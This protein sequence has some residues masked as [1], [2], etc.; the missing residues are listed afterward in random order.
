MKVKPVCRRW[1]LLTT[2]LIKLDHLNR[3]SLT[4]RLV[5]TTCAGNNAWYYDSDW[6]HSAMLFGYFVSRRLIGLLDTVLRIN[7]A[8]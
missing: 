5:L 3:V 7:P 4:D 1:H 6:H 8:Y 2:L